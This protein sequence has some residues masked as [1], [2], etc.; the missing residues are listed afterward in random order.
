MSLFTV[1]VVIHAHTQIDLVR[2]LVGIELLVQAQDGVAW[3]H[4]DGAEQGGGQRHEKSSR[5]VKKQAAK[6]NVTRSR[7]GHRAL[8]IAVFARMSYAVWLP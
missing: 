6:Q 4:F 1:V 3:G 5:K 2:M 8:A 7:S